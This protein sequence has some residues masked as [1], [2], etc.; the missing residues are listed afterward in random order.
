MSNEN[1]PDLQALKERI[2]KHLQTADEFTRCRR[3]NEVML[4][5]E[6]TNHCI[7]TLHL[8]SETLSCRS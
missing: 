2:G 6:S 1:K 5:I 7:T 8:Q 4:E 3:Y